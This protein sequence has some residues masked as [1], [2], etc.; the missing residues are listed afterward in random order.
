MADAHLNYAEI[1]KQ[2]ERGRCLLPGKTTLDCQE[3]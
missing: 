3:Y 1:R 2:R